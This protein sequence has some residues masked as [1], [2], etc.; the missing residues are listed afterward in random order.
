[1]VQARGPGSMALI[2]SGVW[3]VLPVNGVTATCR[4]TASVLSSLCP[5]TALRILR[6][7]THCELLDHVDSRVNGPH[8]CIG[9]S[10][11]TPR[12]RF[13]NWGR[14]QVHQMVFSIYSHNPPRCCPFAKRVAGSGLL[15][16]DL[17]VKCG[18]VLRIDCHS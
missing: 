10:I 1:M 4:F 18:S 9:C 2:A 14:A 16:T 3:E 7:N 5:P 15:N 13:P 17:T 11:W 8:A 12:M 6:T